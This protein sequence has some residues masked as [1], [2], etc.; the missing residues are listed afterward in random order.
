MME[1]ARTSETSVNVCRQTTP[2]NNPEDSH[3]HIRRHENPKSH[4]WYCSEIT[5]FISDIIY[6][7]YVNHIYFCEYMTEYKEYIV[8]STQSHIFN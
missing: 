3:L 8:V 6:K 7:L 4:N 5:N 2:R 1:A